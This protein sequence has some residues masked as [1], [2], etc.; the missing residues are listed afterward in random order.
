M[1]H[2]ETNL[3]P[4]IAQLYSC[5]ICNYNTCNKYDYTK[6]IYTNK[7][8]CNE[9]VTTETN[10]SP[11][12]AKKFTCIC[13]Y[14]FT[15][16]TSLWRHK[17]QCD[18]LDEN[19]LSEIDKDK[20]IMT[21]IKQNTELI[22][23]QKD[24]FSKLNNNGNTNC[25]NTHNSHNKTFNLQVFLNETCKDAMN[26]TDFVN[27]IK[28]ELTDL[29]NTGRKGYIE[30]ISNIIV[31]NLNKLEQ[32]LRPLHCCDLKREILYIKD[33]NKWTKESEDKPILTKAIK[34]I[35][36]QNIKLIKNWSDQYPDCT[37]ADSKKNNLYLKI[38][39][40]SMNGLTKEESDKNIIKII[41]NVVKE[42]TIDKN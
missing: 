30:G 16:R 37:K 21:L 41:S 14:T 38:V 27:N 26:I 13:G 25:N 1:K 32:H 6:H 8:K 10:L 40:N 3:S 19:D 18:E 17:K 24:M 39:S 28:M 36:N 12:V 23:C 35:A 5:N 42:V 29:E 11:K 34:N 15:N 4:K 22:Q 2:I 7:H 9:N 20:I 31:K 33:N